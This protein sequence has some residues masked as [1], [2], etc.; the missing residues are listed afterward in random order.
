M[1][2]K[3]LL[4]I[5]AQFKELF[6]KIEAIVHNKN[7][8][9]EATRSPQIKDL[10]IA[11]AKAQ[12]EMHMADLNRTNP[13]FKSRYADLASVVAASRPA[14]SKHGLSVTQQI[15]HQDDGQSVLYT[16]LWHISG[17]WISSKVRIVPAKNDIQ[18]I[19]SHTTYLKRMCYSSLIGVV[20]GD[21][22]DDAETAVATTREVF[23]KGTALNTNTIP[24]KKLLK[25][26]PKSS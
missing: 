6:S 7:V 15:V 24:K 9:P 20:T 17:E 22:D 3:E 13:Y 12:S 19:S 4:E 23:A 10:A 14:L 21:E 2:T 26:L 1:E 25:L 5:Q 16:T 11:L 18:T 8:Q